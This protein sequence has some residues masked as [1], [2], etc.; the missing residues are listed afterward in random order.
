MTGI[1]ILDGPDASGKTTLQQ[2][3]VD[4]YNAYPIHLTYNK[5][6]APRMFDYQTENMLHAIRTSDHRL[7]VV[8]RHWMSEMVYAEAL[9][10]GSPWPHMGVMMDRVWRKHAAV[11]VVCLPNSMDFATDLYLKNVDSNHPYPAEDYQ[12]LYKGY[13][14]ILRDMRGR[15]DILRYDIQS[16]PKEGIDIF[17]SMIFMLLTKRQYQQ[18]Q[19][20]LDITDFNILGHLKEAKF[21]VVGERAN[22]KGRL[23][24]WPFYEYSGC[25]LYLTEILEELKV[26]GTKLMWTNVEDANG[27]KTDHIFNLVRN[28]NLFPIA[29][30]KVAQEA[31][32]NV[33]KNYA[34]IIH[35]S[36]AKRFVKTD[37]FIS[38]LKE[39]DDGD[40]VTPILD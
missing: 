1:I 34:S 8:D 32:A 23:Y 26:D 37:Q 21:L 6:V 27:N 38:S 18:Y 5:D 36:Y 11:Y 33:T 19:P 16:V 31:V 15:A 20:A 10:G 17:C 14:C 29:L 2:Y 25:S 4:H 13:L 12:E 3:L 39:I 7:V 22:V 35:P 40:M 9:R 30:G 28:H 24:S